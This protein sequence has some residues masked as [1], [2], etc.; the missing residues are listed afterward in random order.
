MAYPVDDA[1]EVGL[2]AEFADELNSLSPF[3]IG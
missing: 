3:Q 2:I 1:L